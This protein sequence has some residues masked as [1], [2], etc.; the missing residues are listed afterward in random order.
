M[1]TILRKNGYHFRFFSN[2]G[3]E[4]CHVHVRGKDGVMKV[5]LPAVVVADVRGYTPKQQREILDIIRAD[6]A[7]LV[8]AWN[9]F[10][11]KKK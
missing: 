7:L 4:P 5:W 6:K 11:S 9:E 2:E 1:P 3:T 8:E 10:F